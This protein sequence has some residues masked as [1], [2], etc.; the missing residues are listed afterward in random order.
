MTIYPIRENIASP[1]DFNEVATRKKP[2]C[3]PWE[4]GQ[5]IRIGVIVAL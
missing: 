2:V 5:D 4:A 1:R 3:L